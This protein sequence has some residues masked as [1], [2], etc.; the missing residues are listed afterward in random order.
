MRSIVTYAPRLTVIACVAAAASVPLSDALAV[1]YP[2]SIVVDGS[3]SV[4]RIAGD[5]TNTYHTWF[6]DAQISFP[7]QPFPGSTVG[8]RELLNGQIDLAMA[9]RP[10]ISG[11]DDVGTAYTAGQSQDWIVGWDG[12]VP[13]VNTASLP[14]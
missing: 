4:G 14:G 9:S 5:L 1:T 7:T 2:V 12:I 10:I 8:I 11:Q 13:V 6:P 3:C